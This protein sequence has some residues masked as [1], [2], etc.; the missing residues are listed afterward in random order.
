MATVEIDRDVCE[1]SQNCE[2]IC[3]ADVFEIRNGI[4]EVVRPTECTAC[5]LCV[6]NCPSGAID[7]DA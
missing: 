1:N 2:A 7:V 4:V 3:P 6:E 5:F